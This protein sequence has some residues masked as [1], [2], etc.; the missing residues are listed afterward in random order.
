MKCFRVARHAPTWRHVAT[1]LAQTTAFW[2]VFLWALPELV[3]RTERALELPPLDLPAARLSGIG[4]FALASCLGLTT[5]FTMAIVGRGTPLPLATARELVTRGPYRVL[6]NPMA[7]AG[8][9]QGVGVGLWRGSAAIVLYAL[10]GAVVWHLVARPPEERDLEARFQ[11]AYRDYRAR[12]SLWCVCL[13]AIAERVVGAV[14]LAAALGGTL[15][16]A[17]AGATLYRAAPALLLALLL[18]L[19]LVRRAAPPRTP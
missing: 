16:A 2:T 6:R 15:L 17:R 12:V 10:A 19:T 1:M 4:L 13:P 5:G 7:L 11:D 3:L 18:G 8:I 14:L 9:A